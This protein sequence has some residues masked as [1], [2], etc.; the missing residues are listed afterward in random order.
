MNRKKGR[1]LEDLL[2][3][4]RAFEG[5]RVSKW[6]RAK[7]WR[8]SIDDGCLPPVL[9]IT[10]P[11]TQLTT[12]R[13]KRAARHEPPLLMDEPGTRPPLIMSRMS[14]SI[15]AHMTLSWS[16]DGAIW[17]VFNEPIRWSNW[18]VEEDRT[19]NCWVKSATEICEM[20]WTK[21]TSVEHRNF[22]WA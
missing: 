3:D 9:Q 13:R 19:P 15:A 17:S 12:T 14:A 21:E 22:S 4:L 8:G 6:H 18:S 5:K 1:G 7:T 20:C 11:G 2:E 16:S 10:W